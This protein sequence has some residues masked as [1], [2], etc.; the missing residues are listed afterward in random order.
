MADKADI[1]MP[2]YIGDYISSTSRLT[3]EQHG[4]YL[5]LIMDYWKNGAL[6][7]NDAILSQITRLTPNAWSMHRAV[8]ER[9]FTVTDGEWRHKRID[10]ELDDAK[11]RKA[12]AVAKAKAA[13]EARW[14]KKDEQEC[15]KDATSNANGV[16]EQCPSS[17]PS[18]SSLKTPTPAPDDGA[19]EPRKPAPKAKVTKTDLV[20]DYGIPEDLAV[21]FL[22]IRKDKR[23]TL[24]PRAMAGLVK[25][26]G[27]AGLSVPDGIDLCCD[28]SWAGFKSYWDWKKQGGNR[29]GGQQQETPQERGERM[30]RERGLL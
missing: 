18:P 24:T 7:D 20:K 12:A 9:M 15:S 11:E 2:L 25:E 13:A 26:F 10:K 30:A 4:A 22:Q 19:D 27:K 29:Q 3:T 16:P 28:R 5:L 6:P 14:G 1:W 8:L 23:Q 17:S 21:Q